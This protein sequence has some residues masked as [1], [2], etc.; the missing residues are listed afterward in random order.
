VDEAR[1]SAVAGFPSKAAVWIASALRNQSDKVLG[2]QKKKEGLLARE[3]IDHAADCPKLGA[4][5]I[6][7]LRVKSTR[8]S[9]FR[10]TVSIPQGQ[11]LRV[12][13]HGLHATVGDVSDLL[14]SILAGLRI[15]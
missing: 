1:N 4:L 13:R 7:L 3:D 10:P 8:F 6:L 11:C 14:S 12:G 2:E 5:S 15:A 9:V